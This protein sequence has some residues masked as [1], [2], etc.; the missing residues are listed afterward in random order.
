MH[1]WQP[2][3]T[4]ETLRARAGILKKIHDF[5]YERG[6]LQVETPLL[7]H[8]TVSDPYIDSMEVYFKKIGSLQET[9][10]YLQTSPEYAM[11][12]LLAAE[13]GAIYQVTKSFRQGEVGQLHNPEFTMLEWYRLDYDHHQLMDEM[14]EL[15]CLIFNI[16]SIDRM[17]YRHIFLKYLNTDPLISDCRE[18]INCAKENNLQLNTYDSQKEENNKN[19]WLDVL[20]SHCIEPQLGLEKPIFIF[21]F[22][23]AKAALAKIRDETPPVASRFEVY[24]KGIELANGFHELQDAKEQLRRFENDLMLRKQYQLRKVPIDQHLIAAL[25]KGLPDCAGVA[26]GIDRLVLLALGKKSIKEVIS[27]SFE[28][29]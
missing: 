28:V 19:F 2:T 20:F 7:S 24:F 5:F 22:P 18:L 21:D 17:S 8:A 29:A 10:C 12:R 23:A 16:N 15:L 26:L 25:T 13:S 9:I 11:K 14:A 27:F 3:A 4:I 1:S 6:V